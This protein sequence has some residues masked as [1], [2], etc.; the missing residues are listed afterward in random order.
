MKLSA[1][2]IYKIKSRLF[3][4]NPNLKQSWV[5]LVVILICCAI[6][7]I[8][9]FLTVHFIFF[10]ILDMKIRYTE[11]E[12]LRLFLNMLGFFVAVGVVIILGRNS[13]YTPVTPPRQSPALWLLLVPFILSVAIT[14]EFLTIWIP[15]IN[16]D[17]R[18]Q[19]KN[20]LCLFMEIVIVNAVF[21]EWLFRGIILKGLLTHYSPLKAI[22]WSSIMFSVMHLNPP[23]IVL[24][25]CL[26]L[27]IGWVYWHTRSLWCCIFMHAVIGIVAFLANLR[28]PDNDRIIADIIGSHY[29]YYVVALFVCVLTGVL[30]KKTIVSCNKI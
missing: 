6:A 26:G 3:A 25:F 20:I 13:S 15:G 11:N 29:I 28:F 30:I 1:D 24:A 4:Y 22:A 27:A 10:G 7:F 21:N 23:E 19:H 9:V 8:V 12:W 17:W 5:L 2:D 16:L 14:T 18:F